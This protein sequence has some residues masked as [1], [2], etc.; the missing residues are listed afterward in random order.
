MMALIS[1]GC[2]GGRGVCLHP[3][4]SGQDLL[5]GAVQSCFGLLVE[6]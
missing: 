2:K 5:E 6:D 1:K 3:Q 4:E